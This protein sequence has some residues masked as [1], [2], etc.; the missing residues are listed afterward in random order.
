MLPVTLAVFAVCVLCDVIQAAALKPSVSMTGLLKQ[1]LA[2]LPVSSLG[3][4]I[5]ER[6]NSLPT[7]SP[8]PPPSEPQT[9]NGD[10]AGVSTNT[11]DAAGGGSGGNNS[12][13]H[14]HR[15]NHHNGSCEVAE[16]CLPVAAR[17]QLLDELRALPLFAV[18]GVQMQVWS[19][20]DVLA[21]KGM[22]CRVGACMDAWMHG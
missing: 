19:G 21:D 7:T 16:R 5:M 9:M 8:T 1:L 3:A 18:R 17:Q 13:A 4:F 6:H 10:A 2:G 15:H 20:H 12:A 22:R 11:P 14:R